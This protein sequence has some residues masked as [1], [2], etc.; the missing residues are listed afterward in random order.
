MRGQQSKYPPT[1]VKTIDFQE[2]ARS[3]E[4]IMTV[5]PTFQILGVAVTDLQPDINLAVLHTMY[6]NKESGFKPQGILNFPIILSV[7]S[8]I[9]PNSKNFNLEAYS[10]NQTYRFCKE[11]MEVT[12]FEKLDITISLGEADFEST[13]PWF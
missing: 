6:V 8:T 9:V 12:A 13:A 11:I 3:L 1:Q 5:Y 2:H 4:N 10:F 7:G